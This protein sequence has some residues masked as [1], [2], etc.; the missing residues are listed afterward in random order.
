MQNK[1]N[2]GH[3]GKE[4]KALGSELMDALKQIRSS[5]EFK[6]LEKEIGSSIKGISSRLATSI[7]AAKKS[8]STGQIKSRL[9]RVAKAGA[10]Q[11]TVEARRAQAVA[12]KG[13]HNILKSM[14]QL[15]EKLK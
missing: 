14:K 3:L 4:F 11:G 12:A 7:V 9:K 10:A 8:K 5:K 15:S 6:D 1:N 13:L 2:N